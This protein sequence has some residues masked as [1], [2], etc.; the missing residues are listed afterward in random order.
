MEKINM[1]LQLSGILILIAAF[2]RIML[3]NGKYGNYK[4]R[5][6]VESTESERKNRKKSR[7]YLKDRMKGKYG[8]CKG[9]KNSGTGNRS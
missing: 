3:E 2:L 8:K 4:N 9:L 6:T 1:A 7:S 5:V